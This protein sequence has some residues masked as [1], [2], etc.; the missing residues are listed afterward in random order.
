MNLKILQ[1]N[2]AI[3]K[4]PDN[5]IVHYEVQRKKSRGYIE[6]EINDDF[7]PTVLIENERKD[8]F[9]KG[10]YFKC[11]YY[12]TLTYLIAEDAEN[13]INSLLASKR[14]MIQKKNG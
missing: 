3:K 9:S 1:Y 14:K 11:D 7:I 8:L 4:L 5:F 6:T 13:K 2:N 12:I 10:E